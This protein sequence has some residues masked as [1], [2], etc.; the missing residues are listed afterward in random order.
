MI[1]TKETLLLMKVNEMNHSIFKG[2]GYLILLLGL[3]SYFAYGMSITYILSAIIALIVSSIPK[4]LPSILTIILSS[5]VN[6][7]SRQKAIVKTL[8]TVET[9]GSMTEVC[10]DKTGTLTKNDMTL[11]SLFVDQE[12]VFLSENERQESQGTSLLAEIMQNCQETQNF[13]DTG[14]PVTGNATEL[15]LLK[16]TNEQNVI[17]REISEALPFDSAYKYIATSHIIDGEK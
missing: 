12:T 7:M 3:V 11:I 10:S 4:G 9:L 16:W 17:R 2:I 15:A 13:Y 8:S 1:E 14:C 5:G 6:N